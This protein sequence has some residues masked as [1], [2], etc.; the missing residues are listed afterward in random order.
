MR[1]NS[2]ARRE[3][4]LGGNHPAQIFRR[5]FD[6]REDDLI[7]A[8]GTCDSFLR[9]EDY[10]PAGSS[11]TSSKTASYF[12]RFLDCVA[13]ENWC[14]EVRKRIGRDTAHCIPFSY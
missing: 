2:A 1:R 14:K 11:R 3:N 9:C 10:M 5:R 12:L 8:A 7:A 6:P 13:I 4:P